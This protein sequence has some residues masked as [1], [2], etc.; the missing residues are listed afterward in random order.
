MSIV[1]H[2]VPS[3]LHDCTISSSKTVKNIALI[4]VCVGVYRRIA[5]QM[6]DRPSQD[7][8]DSSESSS[9][10]PSQIEQQQQQPPPQEGTILS[11]SGPVGSWIGRG[12]G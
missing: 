6:A 7:P 5:G 2:P 3:N 9:Q 10:S 8:M 11:L 4:T 1:H 12:G